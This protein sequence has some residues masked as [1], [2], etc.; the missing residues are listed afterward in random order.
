MSVRMR[1]ARSAGE[2]LL[3]IRT[4]P[5]GRPYIAIERTDAEGVIRVSIAIGASEANRF[6]DAAAD[7][8]NVVVGHPKHQGAER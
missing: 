2:V 7:A 6:A 5:D 3:A 4:A 8:R 1:L